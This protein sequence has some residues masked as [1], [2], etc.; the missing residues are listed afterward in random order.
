MWFCGQ[1]GSEEPEMS[2]EQ[3]VTQA[4]ALTSIVEFPF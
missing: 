2:E 4:E 3:L 1:G